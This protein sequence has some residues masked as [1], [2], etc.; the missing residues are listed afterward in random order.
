MILKPTLNKSIKSGSATVMVLISIATISIVGASLIL[1]QKNYFSA[2]I[3]IEEEAV[4][5]DIANLCMNKVAQYLQSQ[6]LLNNYPV[7]TVETSLSA[8]PSITTEITN[9]V[10]T[11]AMGIRSLYSSSSLGSCTYAYLVGND[12]ISQGTVSG[13]EISTAREYNTGQQLEKFYSITSKPT[14][15]S[16]STETTFFVGLK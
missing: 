16:A 10:N 7:V 5:Q 14:A 3:R 1:M 11:I 13:G 4:T 2:A 15:G 8:S 6:A 9:Y 12:K